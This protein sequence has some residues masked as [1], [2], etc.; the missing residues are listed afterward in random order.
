[1]ADPRFLP[2]FS[3]SKEVARIR[4]LP[5]GEMG[6]P[7][8]AM[9]K[10][11][12]TECE[13]FLEKFPKWTSNVLSLAA[14]KFNVSCG[15]NFRLSKEALLDPEAKFK[16]VQAHFLNGEDHTA[17][18]RNMSRRLFEGTF[19]CKKG[20]GDAKPVV[21]ALGFLLPGSPAFPSGAFGSIT[22]HA[23]KAPDIPGLQL[24]SK[25]AIQTNPEARSLLLAED[26]KIKARSMLVV[27]RRAEARV[28]NATHE[29]AVLG[30]IDDEDASPKEK[31][32][33]E[34]AKKKLSKEISGHD[35]GT[36]ERFEINPHFLRGN[37]ESVKET[38]VS[39]LYMH[40]K[41]LMADGWSKTDVSGLA[42]GIARMLAM[43]EDSQTAFLD[44]QGY[45]SCMGHTRPIKTLAAAEKNVMNVE[46][47]MTSLDNEVCQSTA[48]RLSALALAQAA[49]NTG[50]L[51]DEMAPNS[52]KRALALA[53]PSL[54]KRVKTE[55]GETT[56]K[57]LAN[58]FFACKDEVA[59]LKDEV[60]LLKK[61]LQ[62]KAGS[63]SSSSPENFTENEDDRN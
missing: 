34:A 49:M 57:A 35:A 23:C 58:D 36:L 9:W 55:L 6:E 42:N 31:E 30:E 3:L 10:T 61:Q 45:M 60:A 20:K 12:V 2:S 22:G 1:M 19:L 26:G 40:P 44:I 59:L 39:A 13:G 41:K 7:V 37:S 4:G 11:L 33:S 17:V 48:F 56:N 53:D 28:C 38:G 54:A 5:V 47:D 43:D 27:A 46:V 21:L 15:K 51:V 62:S 18:I 32:E 50:L 25:H 8:L 63:N 14:V 29:L 16:E 52:V 24:P